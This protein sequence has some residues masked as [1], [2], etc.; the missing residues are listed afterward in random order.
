M[1]TA[2]AQHGESLRATSH[3]AERVMPAAS[4]AVNPAP[5]QPMVGNSPT[6]GYAHS[7]WWAVETEAQS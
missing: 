1:L 3:L 6:D 7:R 2:R 5:I 4:M